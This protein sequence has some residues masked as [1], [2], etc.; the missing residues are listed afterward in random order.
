VLSLN[1]WQQTGALLINQS[2]NAIII[3]F[4]A[5]AVVENQLTFGMML[6]I[7]SIIG[8]LNVPVE[9]FVGFSQQALEAKLSLERLNE[10]HLLDNEERLD[11]AFDNTNE[12]IKDINLKEVSFS[13][14][15]INGIN[16]LN[17]INISIA[18]GKVTAIVGASGSGKS[19]LLKLL[20][21]FYDNYKGNITIGGTNFR[22]LNKRL[23]RSKI[24][25]VLQDT[26]IFNDTIQKNITVVDDKL[27]Y[28]KL[29]ESCE[30][31]NILTFIESLP[32]GFNTIIGDL[33]VSMS[34]GQK[35][36]LAIARAIYKNPEIIFFDEATNALD[37]KNERIIMQNF[38]NYFRGRTAIIVAHRLSTIKTADMIIVLDGGNVVEVG[39][40]D[41]LMQNKSRYYEL[42]INQL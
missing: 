31:A 32:L 5:S 36:R 23:W 37:A 30:I 10:I 29:I 13:Y 19:T 22:N 28:E 25:V 3:Y 16:I 21:G 14:N 40:H 42:V 11:M 41:E 33:G 26:Y 15:D 7:Q 27:D 17:D 34:G 8:S 35:Q 39:N 6:A 18:A 38:D 2:K 20:V 9:F 4:V 1:Q 12:K 24:G